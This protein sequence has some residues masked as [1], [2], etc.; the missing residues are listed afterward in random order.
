MQES[1]G[2]ASSLLNPGTHEPNQTEETPIFGKKKNPI[3][4]AFLRM[5]E[6]YQS[7]SLRKVRRW[8]ALIVGAVIMVACGTQYAFSS[9]S[10]SL[11]K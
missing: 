6:V 1:E 9:I 10:P 7:E 5:K 3:I 8:I 2:E 11:K 4:R